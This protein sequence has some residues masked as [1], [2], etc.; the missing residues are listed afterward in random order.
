M[1]SIPSGS[2]TVAP[3]NQLPVQFTSDFNARHYCFYGSAR[4]TRRI[5]AF[6]CRICRSPEAKAWIQPHQDKPHLCHSL[7]E[8]S[9]F[10]GR[11]KN[12]LLAS[13]LHKHLHMEKKKAFF[14]RHFRAEWTR[15]MHECHLQWQIQLWSFVSLNSIFF[16][17]NIL[18]HPDSLE[19]KPQRRTFII[20]TFIK[21][22]LLNLWPVNQV[23]RLT[24]HIY[25]LQTKGCIE[26][27]PKASSWLK[28]PIIDIYI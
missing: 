14:I 13:I 7:C 17:I 10:S 12:V 15:K 9:A 8:P 6:S 27:V 21:L 28:A 25:F 18:V 1:L 11:K 3:Q 16:T 5:G 4:V 19:D 26:D 22:N 20:R 23:I 24:L 2:Q